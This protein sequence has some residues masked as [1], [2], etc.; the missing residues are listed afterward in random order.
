MRL[1]GDDAGVALDHAV[2]DLDRAAHGVDHA[3]E[4]DDEPVARAFHQ[5]AVMGGDRRIGEIA[6]QRAE[7]RQR[8]VLIRPGKAAKADHI[9]DQDR[10]DFP[11]FVHGASERAGKL[12]QDQR[13]PAPGVPGGQPT[14]WP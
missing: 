1:S 14:S 5:A 2:L 7:I 6:P 8:A 13:C 11:G 9:G 3:A 12:A 10:G 4:L